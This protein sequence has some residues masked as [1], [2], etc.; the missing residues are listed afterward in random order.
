M[1]FLRKTPS[2]F[3]KKPATAQPEKTAN[4]LRRHLG[5][6]RKMTPEKQAQKLHADDASQ[7]PDLDDASDW[8][9]QVSHAARPTRSPTQIWVVTSYQY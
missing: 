5:F 7:H 6:P 4:I 9:K 3:S 8:L 1:L 2:Q